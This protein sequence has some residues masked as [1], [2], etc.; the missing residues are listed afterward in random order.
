M[1]VLT[2]IS[3]RFVIEQQSLDFP[4]CINLKREKK[5][6]KYI[7]QHFSDFGQPVVEDSDL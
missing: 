1:E 7:K 6:A 2:S 3:G 5:E 4:T